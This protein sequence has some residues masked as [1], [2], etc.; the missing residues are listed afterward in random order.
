M[1]DLTPPGPASGPTPDPAPPYAAAPTPYGPYGGQP[2]QPRPA[3]DGPLMWT[4]FGLSLVIC[5]PPLPLVGAILGGVALARK[6]IETK[7]PAIVAVVAGLLLTAL[8]AASLPDLLEEIR[9]DM[10]E[11]MGAGPGADQ[12]FDDL[13]VGDCYNDEKT[14]DTLGDKGESEAGVWIEIVDCDEAHQFQALHV[15]DLPKGKYPGNQT[16]RDDAVEQCFRSWRRYFGVPFFGHR[17]KYDMGFIYPTEDSWG[18]GD[19]RIIC[20]VYARDKGPT[21]G[22]ARMGRAARR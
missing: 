22:V 19:R 5:L 11:E 10:R 15:A 3:T 20:H 18:F 14:H 4:G 7:W 6:R 12:T 9:E 1:S 2:D 21:E 17:Q 8:Q 16:V 13:E